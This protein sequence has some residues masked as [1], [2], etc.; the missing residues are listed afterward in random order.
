MLEPH[1]FG[2]DAMRGSKANK[3]HWREGK[4]IQTKH[5]LIYHFLSLANWIELNWISNNNN[6]AVVVGGKHSYSL[7]HV[8]NNKCRWQQRGMQSWNAIG[9]Y[10][11]Y[12]YFIIS[13]EGY[14][15]ICV[16][17]LHY[18][19]KWRIGLMAK[20]VTCLM[21]W[22]LNLALFC[23]NL[24][25]NLANLLS[26][27]PF[28]LTVV[29]LQLPRCLPDHPLFL[30]LFF[31]IYSVLHLLSSLFYSN[32]FLVPINFHFLF[33]TLCLVHYKIISCKHLFF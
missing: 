31:E 10:Y 18:R 26:F 24:P 30:I 23:L 8:R 21:L 25:I 17:L 1:K 16:Y 11:L 4:G 20:K 13:K 7:L 33:F 29:L 12:L 2:V 9:N 32:F 15:T 28:P 14:V 19:L 3:S 5:S 6:N 22:P 27:L